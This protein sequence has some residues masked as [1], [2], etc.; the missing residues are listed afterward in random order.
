MGPEGSA[1]FLHMGDHVSLYAEGSVSGFISTLGPTT[2]PKTH[3]VPMFGTPPSK[4]QQPKVTVEPDYS[5]SGCVRL[6]DDRCV[7]NPEAGDLTNPPK[8]FRD[9]LFCICPSNR[10]SAQKQFWNA[11]KQSGN[12]STDSSLLERLHV[13]TTT[14]TT[15]ITTIGPV[16]NTHFFCLLSNPTHSQYSRHREQVCL[17]SSLALFTG[18]SV[19]RPAVYLHSPLTAAGFSGSEAERQTSETHVG[20]KIVKTLAIYL[21]TSIDLC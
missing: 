20:I 21:L 6:V 7:V 10:Y 17:H 8:K 18:P 3:Q 15:T 1:S 16:T 14:T 11:A 4:K 9:C 12:S 2:S 19:R 13:S 5:S